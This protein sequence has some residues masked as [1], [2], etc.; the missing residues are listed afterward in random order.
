[1]TSGTARRWRYWAWVGLALSP[2]LTVMLAVG[3]MGLAGGP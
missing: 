3:F 1:M 2:W